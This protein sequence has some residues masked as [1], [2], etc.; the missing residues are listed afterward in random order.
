MSY[1]DLK[2]HIFELKQ[3]EIENQKLLFENK[4]ELKELNDLNIENPEKVNKL[5]NLIGNYMCNLERISNELKISEWL[6]DCLKS[7][8]KGKNYK[9]FYDLNFW[10]KK[11][12]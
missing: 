1:V 11:Y 9:L 8:Y 12:Y 4:K 6:Y 10:D 2:M 3:I 5:R 7:I